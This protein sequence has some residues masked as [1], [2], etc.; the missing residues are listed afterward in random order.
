MVDQHHTT[1]CVLMAWWMVD[2]HHTT[3]CVLMAWW[4]VDQLHIKFVVSI[5]V[6][7]WRRVP[8][9]KAFF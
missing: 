5:F 8:L 4:M 6:I 1:L 9:T 7:L 2:Q 3:L